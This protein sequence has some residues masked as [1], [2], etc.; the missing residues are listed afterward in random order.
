M[1]IRLPVLQIT[2]QKQREKK[3]RKKH[4]CTHTFINGPKLQ[5]FMQIRSVWNRNLQ[6]SI[7]KCSVQKDI[8]QYVQPGLISVWV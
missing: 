3:Q 7:K 2:K 5:P 1:Q 4:V 6:I 8:G